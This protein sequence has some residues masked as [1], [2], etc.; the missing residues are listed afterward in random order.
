ME[1][2][3]TAHNKAIPTP[4]APALHH[5]RH[6]VPFSTVARLTVIVI[7]PCIP[8]DLS[9]LSCFNDK[10]LTIREQIQYLLSSTGTDLP[11]NTGMIEVAVKLDLHLN[12]YSPIKLCGLA[13]IFSF[14]KY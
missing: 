5:F 12:V 4:Q 7:E 11:S 13:S 8:V 2:K 9:R 6:S 3:G 1:M 10:T 14:C